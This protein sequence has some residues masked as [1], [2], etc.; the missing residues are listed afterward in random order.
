MEH[1]SGCVSNI[2]PAHLQWL[3]SLFR[4]PA[5]ARPHSAAQKVF[6]TSELLG[7]VLSH[8]HAHQLASILR[9]IPQVMAAIQAD[10]SL[11]RR[12]YIEEDP[13][14]NPETGVWIN[15]L[16]KQ[17]L[18]ALGWKLN[19][20]YITFYGVVWLTEPHLDVKAVKRLLPPRNAEAEAL[21]RLLP[22]NML[23]TQPPMTIN[24]IRTS[25]EILESGDLSTRRAAARHISDKKDCTVKTLIERLLDAEA[26]ARNDSFVL[27]LADQRISLSCEGLIYFY[28]REWMFKRIFGEQK[29][30]DG[31]IERKLLMR[32]GVLPDQTITNMVGEGPQYSDSE[33][34]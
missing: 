21:L 14:K 27:S 23:A 4:K 6:Y 10:R 29:W 12:F 33:D 5:Q 22:S 26:R 1:F 11:R 16:A 13:D 34:D 15:P 28:D 31:G 17:I 19:F 32:Q 20:H 24:F 3:F 9:A 30:I 8:V 18:R 7:E 2:L 25:V